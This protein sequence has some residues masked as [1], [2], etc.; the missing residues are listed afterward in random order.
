MYASHRDACILSFYGFTLTQRLEQFYQEHDL[1]SNVI[2]YRKI[3]KANYDFAREAL[4]FAISRCPCVIIAYDVT[5]FFD[6]LDHNLLKRRLAKILGTENL[7]ADWYAVFRHVTR[8]KYVNHEDLRS[9]EVF[10]VRIVERRRVPVATMRELKAA[11]VN[12][13]VNREPIGIPQGTPISSP[14]ANLYL[15]DF[16]IEMARHAEEVGGFYRRYSDDILFICSEEYVVK[17]EEHIEEMLKRELL[18]ISHEKTERT[19]FDA[20]SS[21]AAQYLGFQIHHSGAAIRPSS[22]SRQMRKMKWSVKRTYLRGR[23]AVAA[24]EAK[25][26][27]KKIRRRFTKLPLRNFSSYG[28]RSSDALE[29][30]RIQRQVRKLQRKF[31]ALVDKYEAEDE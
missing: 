5:R 12:I 9:H 29:G 25:V 6:T 21:K 8:F 10:G 16:D 31:L 28:Q 4:D 27:T 23:H 19:F 3:G 20:T 14:L 7:A 13:H 15:V 2:A 30:T 18:E 24:G 1:Q 11:G 22:V 26:W 17:A